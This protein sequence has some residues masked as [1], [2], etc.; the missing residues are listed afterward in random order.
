MHGI[1]DSVLA[2]I[3]KLV[4]FTW[5]GRHVESFS[6]HDHPRT[7]PVGERKEPVVRQDRETL[8]NERA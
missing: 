4:Q 2:E 7:V 6:I 1:S 8:A 3:V 5:F